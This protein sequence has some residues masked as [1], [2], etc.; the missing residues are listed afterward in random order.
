M[1]S[2]W[3]EEHGEN[4]LPRLRKRGAELWRSGAAVLEIDRIAYALDGRPCEW[5]VTRC[6]TA[7]HHYVS[8]V[9]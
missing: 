8:E 2:G 1:S 5:R 4:V 3:L 7:A 9:V 6:D